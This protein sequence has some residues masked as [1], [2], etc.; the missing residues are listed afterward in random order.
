MHTRETNCHPAGQL[1]AVKLPD[2]WRGHDVIAQ[3]RDGRPPQRVSVKSRT[4]K[5]GAAFVGYYETDAYD[6]LAIV[7]LPGEDQSARRFL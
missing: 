3:P 4:F 2:F 1:P 5:R 7:F 6:W